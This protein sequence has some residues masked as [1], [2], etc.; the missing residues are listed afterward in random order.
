MLDVVQT[1]H[2]ELDADLKQSL[3][4]AGFIPAN[5]DQ[6]NYFPVSLKPAYDE[7]GFK[8]PGIQRVVRGDTGQTLKTHTDAYSLIPYEETF[9]KFDNELNSSGLDLTGMHVSTDLTHDGGRIFRQYV[10]P[11]HSLKVRDEWLALRIIMFNSYDGS[12]SFRGMAGAYQFVCANT[13]V[14]GFD[15]TRQTRRHS[16]N[17]LEEIPAVIENVVMQADRFMQFQPRL[18]HMSETVL[19]DM[20]GYKQIQKLPVSQAHHDR[21]FTK[22]RTEQEDDS[23]FGLWSAMTNWSTHG[24]KGENAAATRSGRENMVSRVIDAESWRELEAA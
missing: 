12:C 7:H 11:A 14:I 8:I 21:I 17:A 10:L 19:G 18:K 3:S 13:S 4:N 20:T 6:P 23:L 24:V 9:T 1:R 5:H 2:N 15:I 22:W 16:G